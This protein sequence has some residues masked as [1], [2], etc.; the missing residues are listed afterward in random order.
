MW[1][2]KYGCF[3]EDQIFEIKVRMRKQI[4]F[5]LLCVDNNTRDSVGDVNVDKVFEEILIWFDGLNELLFHP[6]SLVKIIALL[7]AA[8]KE[9][10]SSTFKF[11]RYRKMILDAGAE[12]LK[13][14]EAE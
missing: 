2:Y 14:E 10:N 7:E 4:Y 1:R 5:L 13:I 3:S 6:A 11:S 8:R 9:Y 12:V